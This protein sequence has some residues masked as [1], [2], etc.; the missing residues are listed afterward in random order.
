MTAKLDELDKEEMWDV[1]RRIVPGYTREKFE[2]DWEE[3]L[4]LKA[5]HE[6]QRG[7]N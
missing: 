1:G 2:R 4:A 5:E 3:F 7:M 6:R